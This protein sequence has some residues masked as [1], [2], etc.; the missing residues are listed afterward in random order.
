MDSRNLLFVSI[1]YCWILKQMMLSYGL[2]FILSSKERYS[3]ILELSMQNK[4][5]GGAYVPTNLCYDISPW[6]IMLL[7][8][9]EEG[10]PQMTPEWSHHV[11]VYTW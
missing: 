1:F 8:L 2:N 7:G 11:P 3:N 9:G 5:R 10:C 4:G 6:L